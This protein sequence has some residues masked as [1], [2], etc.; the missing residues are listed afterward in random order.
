MFTW[1]PADNTLV[2]VC[3]LGYQLMIC[4]Y[5]HNYMGTSWWHVC[6]TTF[7][8]I[9]A[10]DMFVSTYLHGYQLKTYFNDICISTFWQV[11]AD[12]I[13]FIKDTYYLYD[14]ILYNYMNGFRTTNKLF[15]NSYIGCPVKNRIGTRLDKFFYLGMVQHF[16]HF[17]IST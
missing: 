12:D 10:D 9:P 5:H 3:L 11:P 7:K 17:K 8:W 16:H 2:L 4:L 14:Y 15:L 1:V 6:I 13:K